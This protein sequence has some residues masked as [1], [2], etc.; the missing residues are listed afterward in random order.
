MF[1]WLSRVVVFGS[2]FPM[3]TP[4]QVTWNL[5]III[6]IIIILLEQDHKVQLVLITRY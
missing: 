2:T 6:I 1:D 3:H 5:D 4:L